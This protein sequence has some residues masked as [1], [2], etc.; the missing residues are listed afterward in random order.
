MRTS[1][2]KG[3]GIGILK[4]EKKAQGHHEKKAS[5]VGRIPKRKPSSRGKGAVLRTNNSFD[6][7]SCRRDLDAKRGIIHRRAKRE[8][9]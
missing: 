5:E 3:R 6:K 7:R 4:M 8:R 2:Y 9:I 1:L